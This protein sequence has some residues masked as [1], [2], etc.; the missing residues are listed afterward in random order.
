MFSRGLVHSHTFIFDGTHYDVWR[1]RMLSHFRAIDPNIERILDMG[2]SPPKDPQ[3]LSLEEKTNSY[4]EAQASNVLVNVVSFLVLSSIMP[5][6]NAHDIWTKLQAKYDVSKL[7][8]DDCIPSTS[9]RDEFSSSS[10]TPTCELSQGNDMVSGDRTCNVDSEIS[11]HDPLSLSHCNIVS[12]GMNTCRT[13]CDLHPSVD[14][15]CISCRNGLNISHDDMLALPCC[16]DKCASIFS[17]TCV[18][19]HVEEIEECVG[20]G[21]V[22]IGASCVPSSSPS[23]NVHLCLM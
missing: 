17:S 19:N 16:H 5:F 4:L 20:Q 15:P 7:N 14:C 2:L 22:V 12:L 23:P 10:T 9:G 18:S 21:K 11:I 1:T 3:N 8:E 13:I 6:W